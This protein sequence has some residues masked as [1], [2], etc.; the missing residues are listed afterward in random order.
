MIRGALAA[1]CMLASLAGA[2]L[3]EHGEST[4]D[5][6][7]VE[8]VGSQGVVVREPDGRETTIGWH[9]VKKVN[10]TWASEHSEFG[11]IAELAW[12]GWSRVER[13]DF[14]LAEPALEQVVRA[15]GNEQ[16][17]TSAVA[18]VGLMQCQLERGAQAAALVSWAQ[19]RAMPSAAREIQLGGAIDRATLLSPGLPPIFLP[20]PSLGRIIDLTP[21]DEVVGWFRVAAGHEMGQVLDRPAASGGVQAGADLELVR[22]IVLARGGDPLERREARATLERLV[23][24]QPGGWIEAWSRAGLGRSLAIEPNRE[25]ALRG[26]IQLLHVPVRFGEQMPQLASTCQAE[27]ALALVRMGDRNGAEALARDLARR[28]PGSAAANDPR[29]GQLLESVRSGERAST[30]R[31][32]NSL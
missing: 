26:V 31:Q 4:A 22:S 32:E 16:G 25:S 28:W 14:A 27:A 10:G 20:S 6:R 7:P 8:R 15:L 18:L 30:A 23:A 9:R 13:G 29:I 21:T 11:A 2:Q 19:L 1:M 3:V 12:R 17:A 5:A 24:Q